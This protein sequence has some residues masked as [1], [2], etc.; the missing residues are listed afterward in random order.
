VIEDDANSRA[1]LEYIFKATGFDVA[2]ATNGKRGLDAAVA[3]PPDLILCDLQMPVMNGYELLRALRAHDGLGDV[4][5]IAVTALSMAGDRE[6]ALAAGFADYI[7]KPIEPE[8][9]IAQITPHLA[10]HL[11]RHLSRGREG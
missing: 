9:I 10:P 7:A 11:T 2:G 8:T 4:P 5:V 1:L 3:N 6:K